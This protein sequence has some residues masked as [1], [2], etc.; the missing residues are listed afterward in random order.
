MPRRL[1]PPA[2]TTAETAPMQDGPRR[3]PDGSIDTAFYL[4]RGRRMRAAAA[5]ALFGRR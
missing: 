2:R 1:D 3:R 4:A 5:G